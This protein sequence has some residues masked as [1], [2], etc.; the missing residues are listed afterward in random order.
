MDL[1]ITILKNPNKQTNPT[2]KTKIKQ[3]VTKEKYK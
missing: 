1:T 2:T 3:T